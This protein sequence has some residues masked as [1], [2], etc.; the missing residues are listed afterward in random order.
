MV[1][2][3]LA[4]W[5]KK[6]SHQ[7]YHVRAVGGWGIKKGFPSIRQ[8]HMRRAMRPSLEQ[9]RPG[10]RNSASVKDVVHVIA[11][12]GVRIRNVIVGSRNAPANLPVGRNV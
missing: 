5:S 3:G 7:Q 11:G 10:S 12:N 9:G 4:N 2:D 6:T 8:L 1:S